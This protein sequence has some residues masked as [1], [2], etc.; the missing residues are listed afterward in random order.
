MAIRPSIILG[1]ETLWYK[2][3]GLE[4]MCT[5][6]EHQ[7]HFLHLNSTSHDLPVLP[8]CTVTLAFTL[9]DHSFE[10]VTVPSLPIAC[11]P[12]R[13]SS[14]FVPTNCHRSNYCPLPIAACSRPCLIAS[15][16]SYNPSCSG[17]VDKGLLLLPPS[18]SVQQRFIFSTFG[19]LAISLMYR[20]ALFAHAKCGTVRWTRI[21]RRY[22]SCCASS[23]AQSR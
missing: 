9:S 11:A 18:A 13:R 23:Q 7:K 21:Q 8:T 17:Q 22:G 10:F 14:M 5:M 6:T 2:E 12:K 3:F 20:V 19:Y 16:S 1:Q 4:P 15:S